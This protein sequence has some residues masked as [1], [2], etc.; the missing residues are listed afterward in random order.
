M[1]VA[2]LWIFNRH[3]SMKVMVFLTDHKRLNYHFTNAIMGAFPK[4]CIFGCLPLLYLQRRQ[5]RSKFT[6]YTL[7]PWKSENG[8]AGDDTI[9]HGATP[10]WS[11]WPGRSRITCRRWPLSLGQFANA[12]H[13][14]LLT[15]WLLDFKHKQSM[16]PRVEYRGVMPSV[17]L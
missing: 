12:P 16:N 9:T 6:R 4:Q 10:R 8:H 14:I 17:T 5:A 2:I 13:S 7:L 15:A 1:G 3:S 11:V